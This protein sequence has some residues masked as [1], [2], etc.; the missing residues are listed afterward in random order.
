MTKEKGKET[1]LISLNVIIGQNELKLYNKSLSQPSNDAGTNHF[2]MKKEKK[3]HCDICF[4]TPPHTTGLLHL[5]EK[6]L[7]IKKA[8][9]FRFPID[10]RNV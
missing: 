8:Y 10:L 9:F 2:T 6:R 1:L 3:M 4:G 5:T 7:K